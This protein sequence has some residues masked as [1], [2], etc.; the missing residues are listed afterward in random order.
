MESYSCVACRGFFNPTTDKSNYKRH[1]TTAKHKRNQKE[2]DEDLHKQI[3]N[4][5]QI[6][7]ENQNLYQDTMDKLE[8]EIEIKNNCII[9]ID[10][11][12]KKI[13]AL[14]DLRTSSID[15]NKNKEKEKNEKH[16]EEI[17][18]LITKFKKQNN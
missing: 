18:L 5:K 8:K 1:L 4:E 16:N 7:I 10:D 15:Y 17:K 11:L 3:E 9:V 14:D 2:L 12:K 13:K 6:V